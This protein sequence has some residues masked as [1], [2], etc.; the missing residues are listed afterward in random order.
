MSESAPET[1]VRF[2]QVSLR[3]KKELSQHDSL[4]AADSAAAI[5][6]ALRNFSDCTLP[7]AVALAKVFVA[8]AAAAA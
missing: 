2:L 5:N 7:A 8:A 3:W 6:P 4:P 1:Q